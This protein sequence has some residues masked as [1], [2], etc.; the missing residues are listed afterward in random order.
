MEAAAK[1][2]EAEFYPDEDDELA[3][4]NLGNTLRNKP[5]AD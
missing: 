3:V 2:G 1:R 5:S 4:V